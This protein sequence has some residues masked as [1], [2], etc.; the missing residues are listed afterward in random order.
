MEIAATVFVPLHVSQEY[1]DLEAQ[2]F[3]PG[4]NSST[5]GMALFITSTCPTLPTKIAAMLCFAIDSKLD[6][7]NASH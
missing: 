2:R 7:L 5:S 6:L 1:R 4:K 3:K